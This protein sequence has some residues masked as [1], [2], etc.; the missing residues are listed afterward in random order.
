MPKTKKINLWNPHEKQK[1]IM[2]S[3]AR[4]KVAVCGRR[5]GKTVLGVNR[6]IK[7]ALLDEGQDYFYIAPTYR[8]GKMIA[9]KML[10]KSAEKLPDELVHK[11]NESEL[12][13]KIGN[14]CQ[15]SIKGADKPDCYDDKTEIL[16]E[17]GWKR[18]A[19]V[20]QTEK[21][22]TMTEDFEFEWRKPT[23]YIDEYYEGEM[24]RFSNRDQDL[25]ITPNHKFFVH[26]RKGAKK[27][28]RVDNIS[29]QDRIPMQVD[30]KGK[31][32]KTHAEMAIMGFYLAEGSAYDNDGGDITSRDGNYSVTFCQSPGEKGDMK[33]DVYNEFKELLEGEGYKVHE[34]KGVGLEVLCKELW[35]EM[36]PLGNC[37][38]KYI[39][40]E[41]KEQSPEKLQTL[42][43][44]M[45]NGDGSV[46]ERD[47]VYYTTSKQL[48]DDF[49]EVVVKSGLSANV[50][51]KD[52]VP[53]EINGRTVT[54]SNDFIYAVAVHRN[55][56]SHFQSSKK[57]Y[58]S[59]EH[60][61]GHVYCVEVPN[62]TILVRRN[63]KMCWSGNSLRGVGLGGVV[64]DEYADMKPNVFSEIIRP[65]LIDSGGWAVFIGTPRGYNHFY[66]LYLDAQNKEDWD[67]FRFSTY[68]NPYVP[69]E[70]VDKEREQMND[71]QFA[72]EY[73]AKFRKRQGLVYPEFQR[74]THVV[75][76]SDD[77]GTIIEKFGAVDFGYT[78]PAAFLVI[79]KNEM[80][81]YYIQK[82]WYRTGKTNAEIGE[83]IKSEVEG[84]NLSYIY[85]D[86][87]EPDRIDELNT[88]GVPTREVN[89]GSGSVEAGINKVRNLLKS[90]KL[91]VDEGCKNL[92][93]EF[94]T[95]HYP[96]DRDTKLNKEAYEKPVKEDDHGMDAIRYA[97]FMHAPADHEQGST[98]TDFNLY[99]ND[100]YGSSY[101]L[102]EW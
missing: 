16:T 32:T 33:G 48:A 99:G 64:L 61:K 85:P 17:D 53:S 71:D 94:E 62:H 97:L 77:R 4:Y 42:I 13:V 81:E 50:K 19:D 27:H 89:K 6:L 91:Y 54:P 1:E 57:D 26:T 84:K 23:R 72:Q 40:K 56:Y 44:W 25:L 75:G 21:V 68:E 76:S 37:K 55:K 24:Y 31:D 52:Q 65:T 39:P 36:R 11:I 41:Y 70:E 9:W 74:E 86:P 83:Y 7:Q 100:D 14:D 73:L 90:K 43:K 82:E 22:A 80:G 10:K 69:D 58:L 38:E 20:G 12:Y 15:I 102:Y 28:K 51:K 67:S 46:R 18:F 101:W 29:Q 78:N 8:Q 59:K 95:Y 79:Y 30:W 92:I 45:I 88:I 2:D 49:Q 35:E 98:K 60:Y 87:A 34:R 5:W 47:K 3:D 66:D 93:S 63:G 96:E